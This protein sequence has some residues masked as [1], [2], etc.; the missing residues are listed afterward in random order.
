M[1]WTPTISELQGPIYQRIVDVLES[2][3]ASG[4][5]VRG[6][7]LPTH[8]ALAKALGCDLTT[9]TRAYSEAR[10]RGLVE[11]QVGRGSFVSETTVRPAAER[12]AAGT[13]APFP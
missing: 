2:D 8:R 13:G 11:A 7:Q 12:A 1:G 10:R 6:Q 9:V 4:R 5:L 3:I